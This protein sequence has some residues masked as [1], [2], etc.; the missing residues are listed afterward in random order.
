MFIAQFILFISLWPTEFKNLYISRIQLDTIGPFRLSLVEGI[1][2]HILY[3]YCIS[4]VILANKKI[5]YF[6]TLIKTIQNK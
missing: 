6:R 5:L 1:V 3:F 4:I 2:L